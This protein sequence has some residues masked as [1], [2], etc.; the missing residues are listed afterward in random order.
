MD[1]KLPPI[2]DEAEYE[3]EMVKK[4]E[5]MIAKRRGRPSPSEEAPVEEQ[6]DK[7]EALRKLAGE[8]VVEMPGLGEQPSEDDIDPSVVDEMPGEP[9]VDDE[10]MAQIRALQ[11]YLQR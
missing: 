3:A 5:E 9:I 7:M 8:Q 4:L 6:P 1:F 11:K 10:K 2:Q